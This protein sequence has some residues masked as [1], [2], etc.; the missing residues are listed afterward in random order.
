MFVVYG[1]YRFGKKRIACRA[2]HCDKCRDN[3]FTEQFRYLLVAHLFFIPFFPIGRCTEWNCVVCDH[4][5]RLKR[6][7][8]T[9][10]LCLG[11][12]AFLF[13]LAI[14]LI[15]DFAKGVGNIWVFRGVVGAIIVALLFAIYLPDREGYQEARQGVVPLPKDE[16]PY[17]REFT[18]H[19]GDESRCDHCNVRI[20]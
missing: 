9:V 7:S 1:Y 8:S 16:C 2:D 11:V 10:I 19:F 18:L 5:P 6:P 12:F 14:S 4:D 13:L 20:L 17:C 15:P 3:V